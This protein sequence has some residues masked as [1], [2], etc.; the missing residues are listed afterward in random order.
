MIECVV[1]RLLAIV[2]KLESFPVL[3]IVLGGTGS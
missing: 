3:A 2:T 1:V